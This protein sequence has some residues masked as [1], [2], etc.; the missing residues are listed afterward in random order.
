MIKKPWQH[1]NLKESFTGAFR[2]LVIVFKNERHPKMM[3][4]YGFLTIIFAVSMRVSLTEI[5][6]LVAIITLVLVAEI[7]NSIVESVMNIIQPYKDPHIRM[8]KDISSGMV[9]VA[10]LGAVVIGCV[11]FLPKIIL[12]LK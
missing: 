8:L 2:G 10:S 1:K 5:A 9:L 4:I 12:A 7:F 3:T 6:V 11:I